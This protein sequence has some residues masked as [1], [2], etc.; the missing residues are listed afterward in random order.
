[1][2]KAAEELQISQPALS[3]IIARLEEDLGVPLFDRQGRNIRLNTFGKAFLRKVE[4]ALN[5][6]EDG[7]KEIEELSGLYSGSVHLAVA[8]SSCLGH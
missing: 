8:S 7:R 3:K 1:M 2:T 5:A 6:L 4:I